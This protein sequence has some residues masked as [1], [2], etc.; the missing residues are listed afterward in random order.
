MREA[1]PANHSL[2]TEAIHSDTTAVTSCT[3]RDIRVVLV[4]AWALTGTTLAITEVLIRITRHAIGYLMSGPAIEHW[5][6]AVI[7]AVLVPGMRSRLV[8][9]TLRS[10]P[11]TG[12]RRL[13]Q[14]ARTQRTRW[15]AAAPLFLCCLI[16]APRRLQRRARLVSAVA[17]A[18]LIV[19][20]PAAN[21]A[22][23]ALAVAVVAMVFAATL[24]A[25]FGPMAS[26][27]HRKIPS[28][29]KPEH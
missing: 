3:A 6:V 9:D 27:T 14:L 13:H 17:I 7:A 18:I 15:I 26:T 25:A 29:V 11:R 24:I 5:V 22:T 21:S 12:E 19:I 4:I 8:T 23:G 16:G 28:P 1:A 2:R 10:L 20:E